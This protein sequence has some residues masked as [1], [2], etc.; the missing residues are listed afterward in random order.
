MRQVY[1]VLKKY[2]VPAWN[3]C[4]PYVRERMMKEASETGAPVMRPL[5]FDFPSDPACW[6]VEDSYMFGPD[7][8]V[9]PVMEARGAAAQRLSARRL[10]LD[11][12]RLRVRPTKA[13][14]P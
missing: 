10:P 14:R 12:L 3:A 9:S 1:E 2:P 8:L 5:F 6:N 4:A 11:G 7:L 13:D